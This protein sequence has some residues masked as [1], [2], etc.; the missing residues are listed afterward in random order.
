MPHKSFHIPLRTSSVNAPTGEMN[1]NRKANKSRSMHKAQKI[2]GTTDIALDNDYHRHPDQ[3]PDRRASFLKAPEIE[4][5]HDSTEDGLHSQHLRVRASSP[6]L[7]QEYRDTTESTPPLVHLTRKLHLSGSASALYSRYTSRE[8]AAKPSTNVVKD[9]Y[10]Y[11][12]IDGDEQNAESGL[13]PAFKQPKGPMK[14]SKRKTRPPKID[15]SMLFPK[16]QTTAAPLLSPQRM[17]ASPSA[18]SVTSENSSLKMRRSDSRIPAKKLTKAPPRPRALSRPEDSQPTLDGVLSSSIPRGASNLGWGNAPI[19]RTVRTSEMDL[20][21]EKTLEALPTSRSID[22]VQYS[23]MNFSLR[24]R[25]QLQKSD[26]K[27]FV[28]ARSGQSASSQRTLREAQSNKSLKDSSAYSPSPFRFNLREDTIRDNGPSMSKKSS[29]S[30]LRNTDLNTSS[31]LCLSSSE[32]EDDDPQPFRSH[33]QVAKNK[34]DSVSTYGDF[35]A[36]ICT[37]AAAQA[38]RVTLRSVERPSSSSNTHSSRASS[39]AAKPRRESTT[40]IARTP[41]VAGNTKSRRSSGVPAIL[42]P[43]FLHK[44]PI[45]DQT[46]VRTKTP[47]KTPTLSQ[48]EINRRSRLIAVTRQEERLLEV[49]RQRQGKITP[50]LFN[51]A[52]EPDRR[53]VISGMSR[54]SYYCTDTSFLRLSPGVSS[55]ALTRA[56]QAANQKSAQAAGSDSEEKTT[57]SAF[58]RRASLASS[59]SLPSPATSATSPLTPTLPIHRFSP[60]PTQKPPP[61][62]PPPPV[63]PLSRQHS[64]RRTDSSGAI[65]LNDGADDRKNSTEFPIWALGWNTDC[66]NITAVHCV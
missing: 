8:T 52:V 58:S 57:N 60:L 39:K 32:D 38:T 42:E 43:D 17:M 65:N 2:L 53:S 30:T 22:R 48:K 13:N 41:S 44:D 63:P 34:R 62:R 40:P 4:H 54:D 35:E 9:R 33:L 45:F 26:S 18:I 15:L 55:P 31:V 64:R 66:S 29:K 12:G 25:D 61:R 21:L 56:L 50:S 46:R 27:S 14:D 11:A 51:E 20:A 6:L 37:A 47:T 3:N 1:N 16:P 49:M 28:S 5:R 10:D 36:E 24:S 19:E 7:G 23:P 59:K